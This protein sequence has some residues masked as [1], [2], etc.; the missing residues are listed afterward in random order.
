[1]YSTQ[2]GSNFTFDKHRQIKNFV[3]LDGD[4]YA[5]V[6]DTRYREESS[7]LI[8]AEFDTGSEEIT[9]T[10]IDT[11]VEGDWDHQTLISDGTQLFGVTAKGTLWQYSTEFFPRTEMVTLEGMNLREA[12]TEIAKKINMIW[13]IR[14]NR[15]ILFYHRDSYDGEK[16]LYEDIHIA[17][18]KPLEKYEH[19]YDGV[20]VS[21]KNFIEDSSGA[22]EYGTFGWQRNVLPVDGRFIQN[23]HIA[24]IVANRYGSYFTTDRDLVPA[25]LTSLIQMEERDRV[26]FLANSANYDMDRNTWWIINDIEL[27]PETLLVQIR[28]VS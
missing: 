22:E 16:S 19:V 26:K 6:V 15:K 10:R 2:T 1:M 18:L 12:V 28:G 7:Y 17:D 11:I 5:V 25:E 3:E 14:S 9:L 8:K 23:R 21:W 13:T 24:R 4:I 20:E 27:D